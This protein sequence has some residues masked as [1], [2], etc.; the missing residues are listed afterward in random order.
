MITDPTGVDQI[1]RGAYADAAATIQP[2]DLQ[3][4]APPPARPA[5]R[6]A[7]AGNW[8][9]RVVPIA[10]TAAVV[11]VVITAAL[12]PAL[13]RSG[14]RPGSGT[15]G[16]TAGPPRAYVAVAG[17][18]IRIRLTTGQVLPPTKL[19]VKGG[20]AGMVISPDGRTVYVA[21]FRGQVTPVQTT[22]GKAGRPIQIGGAPRAMLMT[23]NGR[24]GYVLEPPYGVAVVSFVTNTAAGFIKIRDAN[25]F[26]ITPNGKTL[27]VVNGDGSTV[28]PVDVATDT[29]LRPITT[30]LNWG[31][32]QI[33]MAPDGR[34][35]YVLGSE[36]K[37]H[38]T[39]GVGTELIMPISTGA[40][41]AR[42]A[43]TLGPQV[44]LADIPL[45]ISPD[46]RT[47][48]VSGYK[49]V[50]PVNL[51]AGTARRPVRLHGAAF[52]YPFAFSPDGRSVY[53]LPNSSGTLY[54]IS[55]AT[56][57]V[58]A[59]IRVVTASWLAGPVI[60]GPGGRTLYVLSDPAHPTGKSDPGLITPVA[61]AS[62]AVGTAI[63]LPGPAQYLV[64]SR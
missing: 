44:G 9:R 14:P 13:L 2:D 11:A 10:A 33:T 47:A 23:P 17:E 45:T 36:R 61:A 52:W 58:L 32:A 60:P 26:V 30:S 4:E 54:R 3:A 56:G 25:D 43:I 21:T 5:R 16:A 20:P 8:S 7:A 22:T 12:I 18:V 27:Y 57:R 63:S 35:A 48:Y 46:G 38:A 34:S 59:R 19:A 31:Y 42:R 37:P 64:F 24:T 55:A 15:A 62:G 1:L 29:A 40:N 39:T 53:V 51:A 50:I 6:E 41:V 28:T 49:E